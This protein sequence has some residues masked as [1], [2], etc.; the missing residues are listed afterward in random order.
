[1]KTFPLLIALLLSL[2]VL[3]GCGPRYPLGID[4]DQW[5]AMTPQQQLQA[6]KQQAQLDEARALQR[7]AEA[8]ERAIQARVREMEL[9]RE[10]AELEKL[11]CDARYGDRVQCVLTN[12]EHYRSGQWRSIEPLAFDLVRG[13]DGLSISLLEHSGSTTRQRGNI[14][15]SFDGQTTAICDKE[16]SRSSRTCIRVV[17]TFEDYRRGIRQRV[18]VENFLK[19]QLRCSLAPTEDMPRHFIRSR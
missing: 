9:A 18:G 13:H 12:P 8:E 11:R 17:G 16:P 3:S 5:F 2:I 19:G 4:E 15:V 6:H 7:E 10:L 14:H 1:M